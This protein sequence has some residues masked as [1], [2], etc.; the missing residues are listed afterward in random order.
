MCACVR[1][2]V[3]VC[4]RACVC[5]CVCVSVCVGMWWGDTEYMYMFEGVLCVI[6]SP[7]SLSDDLPSSAGKLFVGALL[8]V[9]YL[10]TRT[11]LGSEASLSAAGPFLR[12]SM[13]ELVRVGSEL[14]TPTG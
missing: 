14:V 13:V 7:S 3:C 2:C 9:A 4:V 12:E 1:V 11:M 5:V 10:A 6:G 8:V